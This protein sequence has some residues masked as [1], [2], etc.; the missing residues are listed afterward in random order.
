MKKKKSIIMAIVAIILILVGGIFAYTNSFN[1]RKIKNDS[2]IKDEVSIEDDEQKNESKDFDIAKAEELLDYFG[3]NEEFGCASRI[4]NSTY[5]DSYK[6]VQALK[7][8]EKSKSKE[9][10]CSDIYSEEL[11]ENRM[12][13]AVYKGKYGVC[14]KGTKTEVIPYADVNKIYKEMYG[15]EIEKDGFE[16]TDV[17]GGYYNM[18]DYDKT[19]DSF[20]K[21]DC[22]GCGGACGPDNYSISKIKS[23]KLAE[24][25][26]T[27][28]V[29]YLY[30][31]PSYSESGDEKYI[32][33]TSKFEK[34]LEVNNQE[35]FKKE[36]LNKYLDKLDVYE[37]KFEKK[38]NNYIF[39]SMSKQAD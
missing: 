25:D 9:I 8:V 20:V 13:Y 30:G 37:V 22:D 19:L 17:A 35:E 38:E 33:K 5:T 39:K 12:E 7:K 15:T 34:T 1:K 4:Y 14:R 32:L 26:L 23:A 36:V 6:K 29:Y 11:L 16:T 28:E 24:N 21:L 18:Y 27:I 31:H 2:A 10:D 3:F